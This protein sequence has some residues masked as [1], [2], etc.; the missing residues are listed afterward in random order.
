MSRQLL[1]ASNAR[2]HDSQM[3]ILEAPT[4]RANAHSPM[5]GSA[6]LRARAWIGSD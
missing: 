5:T 3:H 1:I 6:R 4:D 2:A